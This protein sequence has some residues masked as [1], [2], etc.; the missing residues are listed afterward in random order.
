LRRRCCFFKKNRSKSEVVIYNPDEYN[1]DEYNPDEYNILV[2]GPLLVKNVNVAA[3]TITNGVWRRLDGIS[4]VAPT[5]NTIHWLPDGRVY[6]AS[7]IKG[8]ITK[9][10]SNTDIIPTLL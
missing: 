3:L 10:K 7:D 9:I 2:N 1:P 8:D 5:S 6:T 4:L